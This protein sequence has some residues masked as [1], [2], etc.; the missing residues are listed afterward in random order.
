M[1][2][3]WNKWAYWFMKCHLI[4]LWRYMKSSYWKNFIKYFD[5]QILHLFCYY[6]DLLSYVFP[7]KPSSKTFDMSLMIT[8]L[9]NLTLMTSP[10][11]GFDRL[12]SAME[13]TPATDLTRIRYYRNYLAHLDDGKIDI[14]FFNTAWN[15]ITSVRTLIYQFS[16][17]WF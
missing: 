13:T 12:P 2:L 10:L 1:L 14:T 9:R 16:F 17:H 15:N 11:N 8:L 7:D 5:Q 4:C 6:F 3:F